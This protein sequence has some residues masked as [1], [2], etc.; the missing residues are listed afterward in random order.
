LGDDAFYSLLIQAGYLAV[1]SS[2][3]DEAVVCVPNQE[4]C[5]IWKSF[6]F[7]SVMRNNSSRARDLFRIREPQ[8]FTAAL[9][10]LMTDT[11]SF[12]DF[13]RKPEQAYHMFL[14]GGLVF[15]DSALDPSKIKSNRESGDGRYDIWMEKDGINYIFELKKCT[16]AGQLKN[17]AEDA[18]GQIDDKRYGAEFDKRKPIWKVGISC[19]KKSCKVLCAVEEPSVR[20]ASTPL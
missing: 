8:R 4:M 9:E 19:Y 13:R 2:T 15:S 10:E 20:K 14:F 3:W 11:L 6:I 7:A 5:I 12:W 16:S 17:R 18:L 1:L